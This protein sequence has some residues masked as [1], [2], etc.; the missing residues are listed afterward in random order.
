MAKLGPLFSGDIVNVSAWDDRDKESGYYKDYFANAA[1]YSYTNYGGYRGFQ[2]RPNEYAL[3]LT[4]EVPDELKQ[5]FDVVF[6][7][8]TL[9]HIFDVRKAFAN[10]CELSRDI[11]IVVVPFAQ[12][13]HESEDWKDYW[14]FTPTC[15][16]GLC[17][18]NGL[19]VIYEAQSPHRNSAVYLLSV[20]SR[21][22]N[23]WHGRLPPHQPIHMAG[24]WIGV[25][26]F[27]QV[28]QAVLSGLQ[29]VRR[30]KNAER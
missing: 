7:H 24:E 3:D 13:Q 10:L 26:L 30:L 14:R 15:L 5:R 28:R 20:A 27:G 29:S 11:V 12:V 9:E 8:T 19:T 21:H 6:N 2:G 4:G 18:E 25:T 16:R 23:R 1:S 22:P 17:E